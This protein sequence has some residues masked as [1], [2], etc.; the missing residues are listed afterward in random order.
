LTHHNQCN[1]DM[2]SIFLRTLICVFLL[3]ISINARSA[4][5][6]PNTELSAV[7]QR[8]AENASP[9]QFGQIAGAIAASPILTEQL[10]DLAS[11]RKLSEIRVVSP[12]AIQPIRGNRFGASLSGTQ[13]VL[14]VNLLAELLKNRAYDVVKANDV[15]P[16]NTTFVIGHLAFHAKTSDDM[17]KFDGNLKRKIEERSKAV[18]QNDFTDLVLLAQRTGIENEASA[19]IQAWNYVID[20]ATQANGGKTLAAEQI[21]TLLVN[22]RYRFAFAKALQL[23]D[24]ALQFSSTGMIDTNE[25]NVKAVA[26]ALR[27]SPMADIQ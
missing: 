20:A 22:L 2:H 3:A 16:N 4:S 14:S 15:L 10:N 25:R 23:N 7:L 6:S 1:S 24:G 27:T 8:L 17:A 19:F 12:D 18:G 5:P 13:L 26:T 21:S 11:S 9:E